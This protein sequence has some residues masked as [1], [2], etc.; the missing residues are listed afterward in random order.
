MYARGNTKKTQFK[1]PKRLDCQEAKQWEN[2][3]KKKVYLSF[4]ALVVACF[5]KS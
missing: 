4:E 3:R 2:W 1:R 5:T